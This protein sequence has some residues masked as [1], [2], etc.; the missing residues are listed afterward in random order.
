MPSYPSALVEAA[1]AGNDA[2]IVGLLKIA[3]PD[4]R[5][6]ARAT[7]RAADVEDAVQETLWL[8]YRRVGTLRSVTSL[9]A[10]LFS[11]VRRECLRL[12]RAAGVADP[13]LSA[14][15]EELS[16]RTDEDLRLDLANAFRLLPNHYRAIVVMRDLEERTVDEI[17]EILCLTRET[18]K[19]RLHRARA[20]LKDYLLR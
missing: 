12:L 5:R 3:R 16:T 8:V 2:A 9:S 13:D 17:A 11:V 20:S 14:G 18:V 19:G 1:I 4:V 6:Y 15:E 7:C 10:W